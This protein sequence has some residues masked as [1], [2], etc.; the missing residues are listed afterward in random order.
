[1]LNHDVDTLQIMLI[2]CGL[3]DEM[4][5]CNKGQLDALEL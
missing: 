1:V 3:R 2:L 4:S 5:K